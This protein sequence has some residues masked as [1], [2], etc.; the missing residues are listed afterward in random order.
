MLENPC[1]DGSP[2]ACSNLWI[3]ARCNRV[4]LSDGLTPTNGE[5]GWDLVL[6]L[7]FT[8][9]DESG[10][11]TV[12]NVAYDIAFPPSNAGQIS[13]WLPG[14]FTNDLQQALFGP[15]NAL[16]ACTTAAVRIAEV[17]DPSGNIFAELGTSRR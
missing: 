5:A 6:A 7:Q 16:P 2:F 11:M 8:M 12:V 15:G 17:H 3:R 4:L 10:D 9:D 1:T 14:V 13:L